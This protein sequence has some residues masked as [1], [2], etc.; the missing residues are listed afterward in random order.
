[1]DGAFDVMHYG[2]MNAFRLGKSLGTHLIVG[3]NSDTSITECKGPPLMNDT[4]RLTMVESCKFVDMVL[5]NCP[6]IM[7]PEYLDYIFTTYDVDYVV[8]G[9]DPCI[10]DGKDVYGSA[11]RRGR[12]RSIPRTEGVS[13]TDIVGRMLLMTMDHHLQSP[14]SSSSKRKLHHARSNSVSSINTSGRNLLLD[15]DID[16]DDDDSD[17]H[18]NNIGVDDDDNDNISVMSAVNLKKQSTGVYLGHQSKFLTTSMM[19]R[20]FSA[21]VKPPD[22]GM[23]VIYVDGAWD[24]FHCGHVEFLKACKARG[25]YVIVGIHGDTVVNKRRGGNLPLMNLHERLLSVLGCKFMDDV[26]IDAPLE[27]TPDMIASLHITEVV[28]GTESDHNHAASSDNNYFD[29]RYRYPKEMG[30]YTTIQS[31]S[32]FK[33]EHIVGRIQKKHVELQAKIDRKKKAEREWFENKYQSNNNGGEKMKNGTS[34]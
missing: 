28:H 11:K 27:V 6:Y 22:A 12:Y 32:E 14:S 26:L 15:I 21:D 16:D 30:I 13:T 3:V 24:M 34:G 5:P 17:T 19:L 9:D 33:L 1:M 23:K 31:P 18:D 10:V 25:D 8:H 4:E 7:T 29:D 20:L 2:H